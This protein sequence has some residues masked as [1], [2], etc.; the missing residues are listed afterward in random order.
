MSPGIITLFP[1][2]IHSVAIVVRMQNVDLVKILFYKVSE[3]FTSIRGQRMQKHPEE[4]EFR[5]AKKKSL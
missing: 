1:S 5:Q 3:S 4:R 2:Q